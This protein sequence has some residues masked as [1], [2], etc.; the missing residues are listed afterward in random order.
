NSIFV[1]FPVKNEKNKFLV[2]WTTT[3]WTLPGNT[4]IMVNPSFYYQEIEIK[5]KEIWIIAKELVKSLMNE[6]GEGYKIRRTFKGKELRGLNYENPLKKYLNVNIKNGYKVVLSSRYVTTEDGTGLVH[7]A[8]GH[9]KEDY[10]V[11][12]ENNLDILSPV[13]INGELTNEAGKYAGK[14]VMIV[15]EEIIE[16]LKRDG[17]LVSTKKYLHDY[18]L[19]WRCKSSLLMISQPQW[20]FRIDEIHKKILRS[21]REVKWIP[22]YMELRMNAWLEGINDWPISRSR[23]WGTPL[24]IWICEKCN[25]KE[26]IGSLKEL[27]K[28]SGE[29]I[30]EIHKPEIDNVILKC[31]C[32]GKM[33]RVPEVLDVWFDSGVSSWAALDFMKNEK[34]FKKFWPAE[35]NLEGKDQVRG[36]WNS[37]IILSE[38]R[39]EKKPFVSIVVHGM[40]LDL[41]K[42]KMSKSLGNV[43]SPEEIIKKYSRDYLRYYF[44]KTSKGEDFSFDEIEFNEIRKVFSILENVNNFVNSINYTKAKINIEDKW[45][46][47][48]FNFLIREVLYDYNNYIFPEAVKKIEKFLIDDLSRNYIKIVRDRSDETYLVLNEIRIGILKLLAPIIPFFTEKIWQELKRLGIV[49]EESIH[50]TEFPKYN[51]KKINIGLEEQMNFA[52]KVI[53]FGLRERDKCG[54]SLKWPLHKITIYTNKK[55]DIKSIS[56]IIKSQL[57]IKEIIFGDSILK[58]TELDVKLDTNISPELEAE[59][60]ARNLSRA[61]QNLRKK[62]GLVKENEI[63]LIISC[64]SESILFLENQKKFI[65]ERTNA[66]VLLLID[67]EKD[68]SGFV[69]DKIKI[70]DKEFKI[71]L[72][73]VN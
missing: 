1:K 46:I 25:N 13:E 34:K 4:G 28:K 65:M 24:P 12:K 10:E 67:K 8:P 60:Y 36:W 61:I 39:F 63:E 58:E 37:Q 7:C 27:E 62:T 22:K 57:N 71:F 45:I 30:M 41:G 56:E 50:L 15:N 33:K 26:I 21:N 32:N 35:L 54:I 14:K 29:K 69:D 42:K 18:P 3:P 19:C 9:G 43:L 55:A 47:S 59:G 2:I 48:K 51:K 68:I 17:F 53:E 70:K 23:Y 16:D 66:K 31:K 5:N 38:V 6:I 52:L 49:K 11:G 40:V 20:F 44:A 64:D 73:R 72:K